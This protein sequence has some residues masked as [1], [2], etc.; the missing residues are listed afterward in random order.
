MTDIWLKLTSPKQQVKAAIALLGLD[1][2]M[3]RENDLGDLVVG[4]NYNHDVAINFIPNLMTVRGTY[5]TDVDGNSVELTP[6]VFDGPHL[7]IRVVSDA[8]K[9]KVREKIVEFHPNK[10]DGTPVPPTKLPLPPGIELVDAPTTIVW[11]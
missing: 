1:K 2:E 8:A 9:E 3:L 4:S 5:E 6:P 7:M 10:P 11:A